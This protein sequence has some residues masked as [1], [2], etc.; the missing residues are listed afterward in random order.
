MLASWPKTEYRFA[1]EEADMETLMEIVRGIRNVRAEYK[2]PVGQKISVRLVAEQPDRFRKADRLLM[3]LVGAEKVELC[4]ERG[5]VS[6]TDV[7]I[8]CDK[9]EAFLPLESLVDL[10]EER[11]RVDKEIERIRGEIARAEGK[12]NNEKFVAKA[13]EA[14]VAEE[15][16]K[17]AAAD[18]ML[19]RLLERRNNLN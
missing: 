14:V 9:V 10:D 6:K 1:S 13:P 19:Q 2:V 3:R 7:H 12:L 16:R 15:R 18:E 5:E 17:K 11:A 8:V 4:A